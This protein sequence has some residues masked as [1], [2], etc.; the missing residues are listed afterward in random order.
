V[1]K[2]NGN[3]TGEKILPRLKLP[4]KLVLSLS[5]RLGMTPSDHRN[6][7]KAAGTASRHQGRMWVDLHMCYI[8]LLL[9]PRSWASSL[10][11]RVT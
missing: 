7:Y 5:S 4:K 8:I 6:Q 2:R 11:A 9:A 1:V 10:E 3:E